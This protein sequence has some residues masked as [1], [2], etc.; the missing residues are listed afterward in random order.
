MENKD[1]SIIINEPQ[2]TGHSFDGIEEY[3]NPLPR[4]WL[5]MLYASIVFSVIY[6]VLY[7]SWFGEGVLKWSQNKQYEE[8][9]IAAKTQYPVKDVNVINYVNKIEN[10][11]KGREI[12]VQNCASCHGPE[13]KGLIGPNLTDNIWLYG[14]KPE[15][16]FRTI[17]NGVPKNGMPTW[18]P[19]L[20]KEKIA[21]VASYLYSLSHDLN[22][23]LNPE[24]AELAKANQQN[25]AKIIN[26]AD[27]I[28]K[29]Q[30]IAKGK[31]V[32]AQNCA[33]CHGPEAK[34]LVGPNLTD[35]EWIHGGKPEDIQNTITKGVSSKGMPTWGPILGNEKI[36]DAATFVYS[37]SHK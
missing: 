21:I 7:P 35:N 4:W 17:T 6:W 28:G 14:G 9:I 18:G 29:P 24:L 1:N 25:N 30:H 11:Q 16:V 13:A 22:G 31:E 12:F 15:E 2:T 27:I 10:V 34:G 5:Y 3:D 19:V 8:E 26:I 23:N 20:G 33:S 32:F 37:L 36:A